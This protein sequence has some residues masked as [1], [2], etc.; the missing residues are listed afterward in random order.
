MGAAEGEELMPKRATYK[1]YTIRTTPLQRRGTTH[2]TFSIAIYW[3]RDGK[4]A[5]RS[6]SAENTYSTEAEADL[7]G[8][9]YGQQIIDGKVS[10]VSV[11]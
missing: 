4:M 7:H 8:L 3:E 2:W 9:A 10:G 1:H 5:V 6:F 11:D